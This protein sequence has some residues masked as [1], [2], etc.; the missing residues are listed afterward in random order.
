MFRSKRHEVHTIEVNKV[1]LN[2]D[3]DKRIVKKDG[4]SVLAHSHKSL[5]WIQPHT[6]RGIG[7]FKI[8]I[9]LPLMPHSNFKE[10]SCALNS[11]IGKCFCG[12]TF[13]FASEEDMNMKLLMHRKFCP[14]LVGF[15]EIR[16]PKKAMTRREYQNSEAEKI[17]RV[18]KHH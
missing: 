7:Y 3:D 10:R 11:G 1:V 8:Q 18:H 4:V 13:D 9:F 5:C 17:Q 15:R 16:M 2:R 12:Q 6:Q 14:K